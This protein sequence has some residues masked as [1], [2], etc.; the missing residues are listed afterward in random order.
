MEAVLKTFPNINL[1]PRAAN[2]MKCNKFSQIKKIHLVVMQ[3][4]HYLKAA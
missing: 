4:Q 3:Y 1:M 2:E